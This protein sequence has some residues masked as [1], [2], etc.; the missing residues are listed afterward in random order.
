MASDCPKIINVSC[1]HCGAS[2]DIDDETRFV[3]CSYCHSKLIVQ[4]T[5]S[6]VFT[7]VLEKIEQ[8][9]GQIAGNLKVIALQNDLN[10]LD[11]EW[12]T[13][14]EDLMVTGRN[15]TS[16]TPSL[17]GGLMTMVV[18]VVGGGIWTA[19]AA[20]HGAPSFFLLFGV[21]FMVAGAAGGVM[22]MTRA[23]KLQTARSQYESRRQ[24]LLS[25]I[26]A[27]KTRP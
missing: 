13:S 12:Q 21:I 26:E 17:A 15:G 5:G 7:G 23:D 10:Q 3:T 22:S 14:R 9:T 20:S 24:Q 18:G 4:R 6:S 8:Q 25:A 1:N 16:S 27:E 2:L 19:F 11:R